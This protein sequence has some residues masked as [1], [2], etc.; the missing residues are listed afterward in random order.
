M[1]PD[2]VPRQ[3]DLAATLFTDKFIGIG[4]DGK[5]SNREKELADAKA[6]KFASVHIQP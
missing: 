5:I 2:D 1:L 4:T 3:P 6:A